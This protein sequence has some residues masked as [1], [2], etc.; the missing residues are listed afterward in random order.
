MNILVTGGAGFIG[1]NIT[2]AYIA[3]G[4]RV[5]VIDNLSSGFKENVHAKATLVEMDIR[6][7]KVLDVLR[8][9]KIEV[10]NHHAAQIDVRSSVADPLNDLSINVM[11]TINLLEAGC[12]HGISRF[13]FASSGGAVYGEQEY[14]PADE[15]HPTAPCSPYGIT[16]LTVEKYLH[17]YSFVKGLNYTALRYTNVY[18]PRQSPHGEAGVVAIFSDKL[19]AGDNPIINGDGLQTRDFVFVADVVKANVASLEMKA[20]HTLN[21]CTGIETNVN[22]IF[23]ILNRAAGSVAEERHAPAKPGEQLRSV[24]TFEKI[25]TEFGWTPSVSIEEGLHRTFEYFSAKKSS[26]KA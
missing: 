14:F 8:S 16:K 1:S 3:A 21:V 13:I 19:L 20:S 2:D 12:E 4:H 25:R 9:E 6:D 24:C 5:V 10:I 18:G 15:K 11:G 23:T 7:T 26:K 17:Y 22:Q